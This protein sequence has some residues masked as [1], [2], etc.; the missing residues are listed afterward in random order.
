MEIESFIH[1]KDILGDLRLSW[2]SCDVWRCLVEKTLQALRK[3]L[4]PPCSW[5]KT[6]AANFSELLVSRYQMTR[7]SLPENLKHS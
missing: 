7:Y 3:N 5:H 4:L 1:R 2:L 6:G